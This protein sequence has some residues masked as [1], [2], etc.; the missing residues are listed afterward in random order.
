MYMRLPP[1][2]I[3]HT[4]DVLIVS[5]HVLTAVWNNGLRVISLTRS[6]PGGRTFSG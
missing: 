1:Y 6:S 3:G 2:G 5:L 4:V